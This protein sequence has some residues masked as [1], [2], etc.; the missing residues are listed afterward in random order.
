V[1]T[2]LAAGAGAQTARAT[3]TRPATGGNGV[4]VIFGHT[5]FDLA[6]VGYTQAE[7]LVEGTAD[8]YTP[9]APL[10]SDGHWTV[11][12]TAPADFTTR[13]VVNRPIRPRDFNGTVI[14]EWLNVSARARSV[15]LRRSTPSSK[16]RSV[17]LVAGLV[18]VASR[19]GPMSWP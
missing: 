2:G 13:I 7:F 8:A 3:T 17:A 16:G 9:A 15:D 5:S 4:A 19:C 14:V 10:T 12:P 6:S 1:S 18:A 11:E